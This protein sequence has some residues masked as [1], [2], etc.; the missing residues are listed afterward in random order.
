MAVLL[1]AGSATTWPLSR[2]VFSYQSSISFFDSIIKCLN[3]ILEYVLG[4]MQ[5]WFSLPHFE[6]LV[7]K[8]QENTTD[9]TLSLRLGMCVHAHCF[10]CFSGTTVAVKSHVLGS[11]CL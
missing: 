5:K 1:C 6:A 11:M 7:K 2:L 10:S 3:I 9:I 4:N 8:Q